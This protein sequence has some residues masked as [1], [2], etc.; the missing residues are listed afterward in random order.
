MKAGTLQYRVIEK[1]LEIYF[2]FICGLRIN[3]LP[4][5]GSL[6]RRTFSF[7]WKITILK[8]WIDFSPIRKFVD[9]SQLDNPLGIHAESSISVVIPCHSKDAKLL[10]PILEGLE[11]NCT[12]QISEVIIV[13]PNPELLQVKSGL[14]IRFLSDSEV[15]GN[16]LIENIKKNFNPAQFGWVLQQ[17]IKIQTALRFAVNT[18]ILV[19]DSDTILTKPTIFV[20]DG[21]QILQITREYHRQYVTQYQN[22]SRTNFDT[23]F[24]YVTHHQLWQRDILES[25]WGQEKL[26]A[27]LLCADQS[28]SSSLSEY[29]T[30][31][32]TLVQR[33]PDRFTYAIWGN[34]ELS[35]VEAGTPAYVDVIKAF[36]AAHSVSVHSY[37]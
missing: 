3:R 4:W 33:F 2:D 5:M 1:L 37:S 29:Q 15:V 18:N 20:K 35:R 27:W 31:G 22:F 34:M 21:I 7:L 16:E 9:L 30:Y 23:G 24:T 19:L 6:S 32:S 26:L 17:I 25:I 11:R 10:S 12:N 28:S 13:S 14:T 36:P 8:A